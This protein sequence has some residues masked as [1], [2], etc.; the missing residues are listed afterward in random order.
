MRIITRRT[1]LAASV[2]ALLAAGA[3]L[4]ATAG[5]CARRLEPDRGRRRHPVTGTLCHRGYPM[6][7]PTAPT[8]M[9]AWRRT[10]RV[11]VS[12][13][14][15]WTRRLLAAS[16]VVL[17]VVAPARAG[18]IVNIDPTGGDGVNPNDV[19]STTNLAFLPGN[20]LSIG[21]G[22][23]G[24]GSVGK[25]VDIR[26]QAILG[27]MNTSG[28]NTAALGGNNG[29]ILILPGGVALS[30]PVHNLSSRPSSRR[31]WRVSWGIISPTSS[32]RAGRTC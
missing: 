10:I 8:P 4:P 3:P 13:L 1:M 23:I 30:T 28:L 9:V 18:A 7:R 2:L 21:G 11:N 29:N 32:A 5:K 22:N 24:P 25:P 16:L 27:S 20:V 17:G 19:L 6:K 26:Y 15:K 14:R 31:L 12:G